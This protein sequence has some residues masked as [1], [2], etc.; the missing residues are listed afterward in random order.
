VLGSSTEWRQRGLARQFFK[1]MSILALADY[2]R[3]ELGPKFASCGRPDQRP[4]RHHF[5]FG[6]EHDADAPELSDT[7]V[8]FARI[9]KLEP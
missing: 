5:G 4:Q 8:G 9:S 1:A 2:V 3:N 7:R 6:R